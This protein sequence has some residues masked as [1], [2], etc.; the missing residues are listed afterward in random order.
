MNSASAKRSPKNSIIDP[1]TMTILP[2]QGGGHGNIQRV[3]GP[4]A[5]IAK[6]L[7]QSE[8][9][10]YRKMQI[11]PLASV[12]PSLFGTATS[13]LFLQDL[14]AGLTSPCIADLKLGTRSFEVNVS[15]EKARR[16]LSHIAN[17][18]SATH[19][20]RCID[21]CMR[22][23][24]KVVRHWD[25]RDGRNMSFPDLQNTLSTFLPGQRLSY[26][27]DEVEKVKTAIEQTRASL[28][29]L[30]L[31][32]ASVMI[33]YDGDQDDGRVGVYLIDFAHAYSDVVA[34]G[35][36]AGEASYDDNS[37]QGLNSLMTLANLQKPDWIGNGYACDGRRLEQCVVRDLYVNC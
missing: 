18:T 28:P 12:V 15:P 29:N 20:I 2:T 31:Y 13:W 16:Q 35:G 1:T 9:Q 11:T 8:A 4:Q 5:T 30:R 10:F 24:G 6:P 22:K 34:A 21:I 27:L 14:T 33:V 37:I 19:A 25:R 36:D 26:F 32:S 3:Q 23:R 17:T 7:I